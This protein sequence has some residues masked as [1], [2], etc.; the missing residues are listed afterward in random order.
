M[1][2]SILARKDLNKGPIRHDGLDLAFVFRADFHSRR[3]RDLLNTCQSR[4]DGCFVRCGD[5]DHA[6]PID[7]FDADGG[8]RVG[9]DLLDDFTTWTNDCANAVARNFK[10]NNSRSVIFVIVARLCNFCQHGLANVV[11]SFTSLLQRFTKLI[12]TQ[13]FDFDVHLACSDAFCGAGDLEIHV[14][15]VVLVSENVG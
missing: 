1:E 6:L 9:L 11:T 10:S 4:F 8:V 7:I 3:E 2:Q 15:Q 12:E 14:S 5:F 13:S